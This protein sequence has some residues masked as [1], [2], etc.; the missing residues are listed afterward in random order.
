MAAT[1]CSTLLW[2]TQAAAVPNSDVMIQEKWVTTCVFSAVFWS[3]SS[4]SI[5]HVE[6]PCQTL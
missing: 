2:G 6:I 4:N 1:H 3:W 5:M